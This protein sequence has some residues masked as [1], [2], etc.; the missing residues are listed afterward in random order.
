MDAYEKIL[1]KNEIDKLTVGLPFRNCYQRLGLMKKLTVQHMKAKEVTLPY[2]GK[3][4]LHD[5]GQH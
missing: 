3:L 4:H 5:A 2:S 1:L